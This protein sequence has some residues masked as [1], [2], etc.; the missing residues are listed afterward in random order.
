MSIVSSNNMD[1]LVIIRYNNSIPYMEEV[2]M[3]FGEVLYLLRK[4]ED[5]KQ[6][7]IARRIGVQKNTISNYEN[8]VSKP[9]YEQ[10]VK[11]CNLFKVTPNYLMQDDITTIETSQLNP[12]DQY[13]IDNYKSLTTHDK[14]IVDHIFQMEPEEQTKIYRFPVFYQS[15]AAGIGKLSETEE[16]QMKEFKLK[17][18]P[19]KAVFGMFIEGRSMETI[20]YENDIVLIDPSVKE[21]S[22]LDDEIVVARF[23]E[24]LICKRLSVDE[25]N[26]TYDFNSENPDDKGKGR[27]HQ[28][29][30]NFTLI[31]KVVKVIHAHETGFGI[32]SYSE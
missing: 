31:G 20:L 2:R 6:E 12:E 18:V 4:Q 9:H 10:L 15:A 8:N 26:Q 19:K 25:D 1:F 22:S 7:D 16:Y 17:T 3:T 27:F 14:E 23:G 32:F 28:I 11:L 30:S 13:I 5:L 21:P 24:E 29:Q